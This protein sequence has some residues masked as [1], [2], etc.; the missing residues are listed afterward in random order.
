MASSHPLTLF[1][2][3]NDRVSAVGPSAPTPT[4]PVIPLPNLPMM[5]IK[6]I[7]AAQSE[8][9]AN[10]F[11]LTSCMETVTAV[12][13]LAHRLQNK[14]SELHQVNTQLFLLQRM[15]KDA[16]A[17][18]SA[19]KAENKELKWKTTSMAQFGATSLLAFDNQRGVVALDES[20]G[21]GTSRVAQGDK[22]KK[23]AVK[24][25]RK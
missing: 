15:Y 9:E 11:T 4:L 13:K 23:R 12:T 21:A 24:E 7:M 16:R 10:H 17:E 19:L 22:K 5:S 20:T 14:T 25:A 6:Q 3:L 18:I 1:P 2:D 8:I